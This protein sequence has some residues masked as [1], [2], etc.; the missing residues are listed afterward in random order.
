MDNLSSSPN[1]AINTNTTAEAAARPTSGIKSLRL[2]LTSLRPRQWSK[3]AIVFMALVFSAN[4]YWNAFD[5]S[6]L[7]QRLALSGAAFILL[8]ALSSGEYIINDLLD[9]QKDREHPIKRNRPLASGRLSPALA[10]IAAVL[11]IAGGIAGSFALNLYFGLVAVAYTAL[12]LSYSTFLK[13]IIILDIFAIAAG[14]VLRA[15]GGAVAISV[16][17][18]PW[19]YLCTALGALF[20]GI[21]K[22][23]HELLLLEGNASKHRAIL[24]EYTT[25]FLDS[26]STVVASALVVGY[27]LYTFTAQGLPSNHFMM[28]TIPF[29][30]YGVLR[31]QYLVHVKKMGGSPEDALLVDK[32]LILD[33]LLWV[34]ASGVILAVFR[35]Y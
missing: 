12:V 3:N 17:I 30:L 19:L 25:E 4:Q 27:S 32:P 16:P 22:R 23:R 6:E 24:E 13:H 9:I 15:V 8:C 10:L 28:L 29:V 34:L 1:L 33:I 14:F 20:L 5:I 26:M 7:G 18:S 11:L 2:L 31:Y 21:S 35:S